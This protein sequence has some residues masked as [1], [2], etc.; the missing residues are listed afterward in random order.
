M[1]VSNT[2]GGSSG[3]SGGGGSGGGCLLPRPR[4]APLGAASRLAADVSRSVS[5]GRPAGQA[6]VLWYYRASPPVAAEI[7]KSPALRVLAG[8]P[9]AVVGVVWLI[10][11]PW[12]GFGLLAGADG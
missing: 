1:T 4:T 7:K 8:N 10:L 2:T 12:L 6:F 11:H 9:V 3:S 5:H